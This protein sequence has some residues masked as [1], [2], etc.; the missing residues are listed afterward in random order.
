[1]IL[2][3]PVG[4]V[5]MVTSPSLDVWVLPS[6]VTVHVP[7]KTMLDALPTMQVINAKLNIKANFF[8]FII[9]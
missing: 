8:I 3:T 2:S 5:S 4:L 1:M 7:L 6:M 9:L